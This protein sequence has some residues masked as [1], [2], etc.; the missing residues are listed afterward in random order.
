MEREPSAEPTSN[1]DAVDA[2]DLRSVERMIAALE[3]PADDPFRLP[4]RSRSAPPPPEVPAWNLPPLPSPP[5]EQRGGFLAWMF[6]SFGLMAFTCGA[7]MLVWSVVQGREE[8][9]TVGVPLALGG[10]GGIIFGLMGLVEAASHRQKQASS[11]LDDYRQRIML[12]QN[13]S[14][15]GQTS[16]RRAA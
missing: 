13:L 16:Q 3:K 4:R 14:V 1:G 11:L 10:Q 7:I 12:L 9:W 5:P 6:L 15:A 8:L 2:G